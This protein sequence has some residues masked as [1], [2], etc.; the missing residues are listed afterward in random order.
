M[1]KS[2]S[3]SK[4]VVKK[5]PLHTKLI[6]KKPYIEFV[7]AFL[8]IPVLITVLL[9]NFNT[10]KNIGGQPTPTPEPGGTQTGFYAAPIGTNKPAATI[11]AGTP[12]PCKNGLGPIS[13][14]TPNENDIVSNNPVTININ[15]DNSVYCGAAWSYRINGST[16]SG[17]DDRSLALYNL[18]PGHVKF[19]LRV[20]S[21]SS[22][23]EKTVTRNFTYNGKGTVLIPNSASDSAK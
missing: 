1:P 22:S 5:K 15:Y 12:G 19:E 18:P 7:T 14:D 20:K 23:N 21:I 11:G 8:S 2:A 13:I 3:A 17:Y 16:W 9:L 4:K 6:K 10:L